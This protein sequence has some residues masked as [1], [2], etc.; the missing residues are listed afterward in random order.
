MGSVVSLGVLTVALLFAADYVEDAFG[1]PLASPRA[2]EAVIPVFMVGIWNATPA[3]LAAVA[4]WQRAIGA[5]PAL[6]MALVSPA[7]VLYAANEVAH[8][9]D[10]SFIRL[11]YL[12]VPFWPIV[13]SVGVVVA[14]AWLKRRNT[15]AR[16]SPGPG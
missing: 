16:A 12:F 3:A 13:V 2:P 5:V 7:C 15:E 4:Y 10:G 14:L 8:N 1:T 11:A 9:P 6:A